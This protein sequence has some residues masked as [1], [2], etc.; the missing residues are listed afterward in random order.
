MVYVKALQH[1]SPTIAQTVG[2]LGPMF[3][4]FGGLIVFHEHF[5]G[6]QW[7]GFGVL[8]AGLVLSFN[9]RLSE[10]SHLAAGLGLGVVLRVLS[11][12]QRDRPASI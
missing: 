6:L 3:L 7:I 2:Q 12:S 11:A 4:L 5:S 1:S 9:N 10:L 8:L